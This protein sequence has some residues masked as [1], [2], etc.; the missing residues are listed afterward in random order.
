MKLV[1]FGGTGG[2]GS[3][4]VEQA[5]S[6]GHAVTAVARRPEAITL[7]H[8][9]LHVIKG[10]VLD[11]ASVEPLIKGQ[12]AVISALNTSIHEPATFYSTAVQN[13]LRAMEATGV[14]RLVCISASLIEDSPAS[15]NLY[16]RACSKTISSANSIMEATLKQSSFDWT[17][18]RPPRLV[19]GPRTG[20]YQ[21]G[22]NTYLRRANTISRADV[23]DCILTHLQDANTYRK[24]VEIAY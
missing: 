8:E 15:E 2:I 3:Q 21:L 11:Y 9:R 16:W 18:M 4:V 23:A 22:M 7:Q 6:A 20:H 14:R 12:D 17:V 19:Q 10:D 1:I 13:M 24:W 5:L